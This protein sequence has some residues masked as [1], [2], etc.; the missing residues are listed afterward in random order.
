MEG[1]PES[2]LRTTGTGI[3]CIRFSVKL[4]SNVASGRAGGES[5]GVSMLVLG[6]DPR[7][8]A[9]LAEACRTRFGEGGGPE[10]VF[11]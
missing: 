5:C 3:P 8:F 11:R 7:R 4:L 6:P 9:E 2:M 10:S 1:V